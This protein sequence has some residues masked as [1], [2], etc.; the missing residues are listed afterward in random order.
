MAKW[1]KPDGTEI[2][3]DADDK[4]VA[5]VGTMLAAG[6]EQV[7]ASIGATVAEAVKATVAEAVAPINQRIEEVAKAK[8]APKPKD[9][10]Q[11]DPVAAA[12]ARA[13]APVTET[14]AKLQSDREA[15]Q[16][17][18]ATERLAR[19]TIERLHPNMEPA[20]RELLIG[21]A[22]AAAPKDEA[23]V[24]AAIEAKRIEWKT[25]GVDVAKAFGSTSAAEGGKPTLDEEAARKADILNR[26]K[27]QE[28]AFKPA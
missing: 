27:N 26:L 2:D 20:R 21:A 22:I 24:K 18:A 8:P 4:V 15:E 19:S 13:L 6:M 10:P 3:I 25:A 7:T 11:D 12:V 28:P 23:A 17:R 5:A 9:D 16:T 1:K 14:L